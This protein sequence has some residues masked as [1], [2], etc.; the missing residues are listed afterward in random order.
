MGLET[1]LT[2]DQRLAVEEFRKRHQTALLALLF[3]D[4]EGSTA[5]RNEMG[6]LPASAL[7]ARHNEV[8][9]EVLGQFRDAQEIS[10]AGDSFFL[11][12]AKPSDAVR[13]ALLAQSRLR[14]L[15]ARERPDFGVKMGIHLGEV[16]VEEETEGGPVL[17]VLG[18]Q[19]AI[20][21]RAAG[22]AIGGQILMTRGV[23]DNARQILKGQHLPDIAGLSRLSHG[24]YLLKGFD[25]RLAICEVG[26]T[27]AAPL[28]APADSDTG[29]RTTIRGSEPVLGWRPAVEQ[30]VPN[31]EWALERQIGEGGFGEVWLARHRRTKDP[32]VFKFCFRADRLR[33]LKREVT[34]FRVLKEVLG[35][36]EDIARLLDVQFEEIPY[37]LEFEYTS[38]GDLAGWIEAQGGFENVPLELRLEI[39]AQIATALA[40][41]HSVGV[42][43]KDVKPSNVLVEERA[44]RP[45][46]PVGPVGQIGPVG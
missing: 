5:L 8:I 6:E 18:M 40:A 43:H 15:A 28:R 17:D 10:T 21:A 32:R 33:N 38:G 36:R 42:M 13:F 2:D 26:E 11:V 22:L 16:V 34:L 25:E 30:M 27:D 19:V 37:Y 29:K 39:V 1:Q 12:F 9:R 46:G 3:S 14:E 7:L 45:V 23:F 20:A 4:V 35:T 41:A 31:T 24:P 44:V